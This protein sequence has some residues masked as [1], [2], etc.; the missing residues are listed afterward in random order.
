MSRSAGAVLLLLILQTACVVYVDSCG[1]LY[2][3]PFCKFLVIALMCK[4]L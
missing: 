4:V 2:D 1:Q 3:S